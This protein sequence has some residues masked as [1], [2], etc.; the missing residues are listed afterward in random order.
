M[1]KYSDYAFILENIV[2]ADPIEM[3]PS[4]SS[5]LFMSILDAIAICLKKNITKEEFQLCH[6][7]GALG[8]KEFVS[9]E[10]K[11][12]VSFEKRESVSFEK[13]DSI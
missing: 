7:S 11:E 5:L 12:S 13:K 8:K 6:P 4:T 9:F 1:E 3:T 2:E 10:K